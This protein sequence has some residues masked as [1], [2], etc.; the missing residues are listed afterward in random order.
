MG[1]RLTNEEKP[2]EEFV[3]SLLQLISS[4]LKQNYIVELNGVEIKAEKLII[5]PTER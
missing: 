3:N 1:S 2:E 5:T 4:L